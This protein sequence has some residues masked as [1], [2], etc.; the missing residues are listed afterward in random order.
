MV[1]ELNHK[2]M[3]SRPLLQWLIIR[4]RWPEPELSLIGQL[5]VLGRYKGEGYRRL[6]RAW[7]T[8]GQEINQGVGGSPATVAFYKDGSSC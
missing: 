2:G 5:S 7:P 3:R 8:Y 6:Y 4:R 1:G